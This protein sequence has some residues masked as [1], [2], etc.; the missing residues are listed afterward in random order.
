MDLGVFLT[1]FGVT[2]VAELPDKSLFASLVLG[3]RFRPLWVWLGVA[4]AFAVHVTIAV[5]A[6]G[7]V[8]LLPHRLVLAVVAVLF[9]AGSAYLLFGSEEEVE[10]EG[11][12]EAEEAVEQAMGE[13]AAHAPVSTAGAARTAFLTSFGVIFVGEFGDITQIT[14]AN[15]AARYDEPL[16]VWL[17]AFLALSGISAAAI[18]AG[19]GLL[20]VVPVALVRRVAGIALALLA[21]LTVVELIRG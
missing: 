17:G 8:T 1:V 5:I 20:R 4:C 9:A 2:V 18:W 16:S 21:L 14:T 3:T 10:E 6:G 11:E 19:R 7:L 15:F 12:Q 13:A